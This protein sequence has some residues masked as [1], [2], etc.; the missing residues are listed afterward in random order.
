MLMLWLPVVAFSTLALVA[1]IVLDFAA[2]RFQIET[3]PLIE[4]INTLLPQTQC[5]QCGYS[6]C[7]SY[8]EAVIGGAPL[9]KCVPGGNAVML[10]IA[11]QLNVNPQPIEG[12][13]ASC[14]EKHVVWID[15]NNCIAC[16]KCIKACPVDAIVGAT[17]AVHTVVS[18]LCTGCDLCV[19]LCPTNCIRIR[20]LTVT[21]ATWKWDLR[22]IPV[23][24][25]QQ[26]QH[27]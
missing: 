14:P 25:I 11:A 13:V 20:P 17:C 18:D 10:K 16:S 6:G 26:E 7:H 5:A 3:D 27:V 22:T 2:R 19:A 21:Q 23:M 9:N 15:E 4:C 8:A 1:G 24:L 12:E